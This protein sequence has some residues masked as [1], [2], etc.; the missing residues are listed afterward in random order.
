MNCAKKKVLEK[1]GTRD[2]TTAGEESPQSFFSMNASFRYTIIVT[3]GNDFISCNISNINYA[4]FQKECR[5]SLISASGT[6][7]IW[8]WRLP[9]LSRA[10]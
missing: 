4:S 7:G 6:A 10:C 2:A 5:I 8:R 3:I 1:V 9:W